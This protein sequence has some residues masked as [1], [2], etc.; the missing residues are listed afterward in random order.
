MPE[1]PEVETIRRGIEPHV[2]GKRIAR[3]VVHDRRLRWPVP[4]NFARKL[5]G[6]R[7]A[8]VARRG[9][10]LLLDL[11]G[12][13]VILHMGMT[14][15]LFVLPPDTPWRKHDHVDFFLERGKLLRFHD[16]RRF[17][18]ALWWPAAQQ[19]H[20]LLA[21]MGPEPLADDFSA[22]YLFARSRGRSAAVKSFLMDGRIVVGVG[23]IYAV[24]ALFRAGIRPQRAA[25]RLTRDDCTRL[26]AAVRAVLNEAIEQG[27][28]TFRD[29]QGAQGDPGEFVVHLR[30]YDRAGQPCLTCGTAIKRIVI[31][32]RSTFY[33]PRC[34]R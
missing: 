6:R 12:D 20:P 11:T 32:Q 18:A 13:R 10:Y 8:G 29:F 22:E 33:C 21:G 25:G 4:A 23:N 31:G 16:P 19:S 3:V 17:G 7:I 30:V 14:G 34:Q 26:V 9:K 24:E 5:A 2:V 27:G 1:L 28:T 15:R